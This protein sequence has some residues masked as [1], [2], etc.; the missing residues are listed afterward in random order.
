MSVETAV[1]SNP[2]VLEGIG[3]DDINWFDLLYG[4][5]D[6]GWL[7][8]WHAPEKRTKWVHISEREAALKYAEAL[9]S[10]NKDVYFGMGL[11]QKELDEKERGKGD[12]VYC[13]TCF[14]LDVDVKSPM[15]AKTN[16]PE[17]FDEAVALV[18]Q[19]PL[20][21]TVVV[22]S[23][24]GLHAY[25]LLKQPWY[26]SNN[27]ERK[28]AQFQLSQFQRVIKNE[29]MQKGW[30]LDNTSDLARVLRVP[31]TFNYKNPECP[32]KV[33]IMDYHP[34]RLYDPQEFEQF[35]PRTDSTMTGTEGEVTGEVSIVIDNCTFIQYCRDNA[36]DLPENDWFAM[37]GNLCR[38]RGGIEAC[39]AFS[40][41]Y[42]EYSFEETEA[43]I[44]H[45]L[46]ESGP[47]TCQYIRGEVGFHGCPVGGCGVKSP[48]A[49]AT[50]AS[51]KAIMLVNK[52]IQDVSNTPE[53]AFTKE[54]IS[55]LALL[56]NRNKAEYGKAI[57]QIKA[58]VGSKLN[59]RHLQAA[60]DESLWQRDMQQVSSN[61][62]DGLG[63]E[64]TVPENWVV[65]EKGVEAWTKD[66]R[67][68]IT[69]VPITIAS[70]LKNIDDNTEKVELV[71]KRDGSWQTIRAERSTVFSK[72]KIIELANYGLP[73]TSET[74]RYL[75]TY[76]ADIEAANSIP[77]V[78][79]VSRLGWISD[80][81]FV[82]Y[83]S[84]AILDVTSGNATL[85][86]AFKPSGTLNEWIELVKP[87]RETS[88]GRFILGAGLAAPMMERL[89][90]RNFALHLWGD[91]RA[92]KSAAAKAALSVW[93][94]PHTGMMTFNST[95]VGLEHQ[96]GFLSNLP[97]VID[98]KQ[99]VADKQSFVESLI[100]MMGEGK[101]KT[102]GTKSGGLAEYKNWRTLAITT[103]EGPISSENSATGIKSRVLEFHSHSIVPESYGSTLHQGLDTIHGAAGV[104][105]LEKL[106]QYKELRSL[107]ESIRLKLQQEAPE[108]IGSHHGALAT[109]ATA[110]V[111][112]AHWIFGENDD[113][114]VQQCWTMLEDI[115]R[116]L[117]TKA[118]ADEATRALVHFLSW[119]QENARRF[120][121]DAR[122][123]F[124]W[125]NEDNE[126]IV[127]VNSGTF[128]KAMKE[129]GYNPTRVK[130]DFRN[131]L[132]LVPHTNSKGHEVDYRSMRKPSGCG[133]ATVIELHLPAQL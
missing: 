63:Y 41:P 32:I 100:Y 106:I 69:S 35:L 81:E 8:I 107:Y 87:L 58:S 9:S 118:E 47:H 102:R 79:T 22:K 1:I 24:N 17:S 37:V 120:E 15:H 128:S 50:S 52:L 104:V 108:L 82:P 62:F 45:C 98:E 42:P 57:T 131:R 91:S 133:N 13:I 97:L 5:C 26:F 96:V 51:F 127:Y 77:L 36:H 113:V 56:K 90:Q 71:F 124:G 73:V 94:N 54:Y 59:L 122:Y 86:S 2:S 60:V 16:L 85:A 29:A 72:S 121:V 19:F 111:L 109:I 83:L 84:N 95:R 6:E 132:W 119:K 28:Q 40:K 78:K 64:F 76:L 116:L 46:K 88:L 105:F 126:N 21:P 14:W 3:T 68:M 44:N 30:H 110:D 130:A 34:E 67:V 70:R 93:G 33:E 80:R 55:A 25:W 27:E 115:V 49:M 18:C 117:E 43:K 101:G 125:V 66:G 20:L 99:I 53:I 39:H 114:A 31:G 74:A 61:I 23:A 48:A 123:E 112:A 11:R 7:T 103:G 4:Q 129:G 12:D 10:R 92:G 38:C 75:V 89:G 65:T